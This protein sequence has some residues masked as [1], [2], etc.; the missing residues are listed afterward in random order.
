MRRA[1]AIACVLVVISGG[2]W[3]QQ[4][5]PPEP[6]SRK[7][8]VARKKKAPAKKRGKAA[9]EAG[10]IPAQ[11]MPPIPATL[12]N[13]APVKPNVTMEGGLRTI[14]APNSTLSDVLSGVHKA[15]GATI[16]GASPGERVA[17]R[18]GP[19]NPGQ[20]LAA[21]LRGTPYDYVIMGS[22]ER[23]D[24]VTRVLLTQQ[25]PA[26]GGQSAQALA[27]PGFRR[28]QETFQ[29]QPGQDNIADSAAPDDTAVQPV[30][31]TEAEQAPQPP[32][33][34]QN[35][36]KTPEQLFRELQRVEQQQPQQ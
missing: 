34:E 11:I 9:S 31:D 10:Q 4:S 3:A 36:P 23:E 8:D 32:P 12:M 30:A 21:L 25:S 17:V 6:S 5:G 22:Q 24:A 15:T 26:G 1:I 35:Q 29:P 20:V 13:S 28:P 7:T 27:G 33:Q 2:V 14:D 18:L 16:E 19:G